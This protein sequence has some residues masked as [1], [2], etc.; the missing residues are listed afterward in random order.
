MDVDFENR[1]SEV[2]LLYEPNK[3]SY[4]CILTFVAN[5]GSIYIDGKICDDR[6]PGT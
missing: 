3:F 6:T 1:Y 2:L 5:G 4:N